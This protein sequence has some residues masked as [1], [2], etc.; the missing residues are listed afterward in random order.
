M[1]T[2]PPP[3]ASTADKI[4]DTSYNHEKLKRKGVKSL[5]VRKKPDKEISDDPEYQRAVKLRK[6][7]ERVFAVEKKY[8]GGRR[9][10][11]WGKIK[12][13]IQN[14]LIDTVYD[15]KVMAKYLSSSPGELCQ[16][17]RN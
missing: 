10:R 15:L 8:H 11:Y 17:L 6:H 7:V 14:L 16:N 1:I 12:V 4:Y 13:T 3:E 2:G 9:A 5:I